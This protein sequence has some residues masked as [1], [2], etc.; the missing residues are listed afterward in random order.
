M[1]ETDRQGGTDHARLMDGIYR[2]QRL[3]YDI[4]RKYFLLGRDRLIAD[5]DPPESGTV[6][7]IACGTGRNLHRIGQR[8]PGRR[9]YGLDISE[10]ML[11]SAR[12]KL[13]ERA[14]LA[15]ADACDFDPMELF[16]V[17]S[18]D[19]IVLSYSLSM[20]PDWQ[21]AMREATRHLAPGGSLH[22]VDFGTQERLPNWFRSALRTWLAKFH[23]APRTA[24]PDFLEVLSEANPALTWSMMSLYRCYAQS[25]IV[26]RTPDSAA[27]TG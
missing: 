11:T 1:T 23:V 12:L 22:V 7:E 14:S 13:G 6:L 9:L 2:R 26:R 3:I 10:E 15:Q 20:I 27:E 21:G 16:G 18:F 25:A 17:E 8:W 4:T 24:M 5:L 19:R